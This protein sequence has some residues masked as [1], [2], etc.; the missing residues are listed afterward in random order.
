M[1]VHCIFIILF[2]YMSSKVGLLSCRLNQYSFNFRAAKCRYLVSFAVAGL[3]RVL[4]YALY[5]PTQPRAKNRGCLQKYSVHEDVSYMVACCKSD[6][7]S[8]LYR[9]KIH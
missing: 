2:K 1:R 5:F 9:M 6:E 4:C 8:A 7:V 3:L